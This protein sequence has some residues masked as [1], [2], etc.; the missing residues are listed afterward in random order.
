MAPTYVP[1]TPEVLNWA[2]EQSGVDPAELAEGAKTDPDRILGWLSGEEQPTKTEFK[3]VVR[4]LRRPAAF[5][6]LAEP[7]DEEPVPA[8]F[9]HAPGR[10]S[11]ATRK[12]LD[13][14]ATARR[15]QQIARWTAE[16]VDDR[17][18]EDDPAPVATGTTSPA[19]AAA[20]AT[21][22][23]AWEVEEQRSAVS[24]TAVVKL[25]R[26]KLEDR[27]VVALQLPIGKENCRGFSLYDDVKPVVA[28][29]TAYNPQARLFTYLHE[30][31]H[32]M[33]RSDAICIGYA[34]SVTERWCER[35]AAAFLLPRE[36]LY[37][38]IVE[39]YGTDAGPIRD[40][41]S[42]RRL[43]GDFNVSLT[44]TAIRLEDLGWGD[45]LFAQIPRTADDK[46][47][48]G[49]GDTD[50][51]R[52]ATRV[53]QMGEGYFSLLMAAE[54]EGALGRQDVLRYLDVS[55]GQLRSTGIGPFET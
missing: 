28:I 48:G 36:D 6:L 23:L 18:W 4:V 42:V 38:R 43:A 44:A 29:N 34:S 27:G 21:A 45:G 50:T 5:F 16:R 13:A 14:I 35:F 1:L 32:L 40:V 41:D 25:V 9:R 24:P 17:R 54:R 20:A 37:A 39:R 26:T 22:W 19:D 52:G 33:R 7:P 3:A 2:M 31:G 11:D 51:G 15:T 10:Q 53:R 47:R 12:E 49:S 46:S 30:V 55:E 8:A